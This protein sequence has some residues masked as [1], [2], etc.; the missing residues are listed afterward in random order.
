MQQRHVAEFNSFGSA[1][2]NP[3][4][5]GWHIFLQQSTLIPLACWTLTNMICTNVEVNFLFIFQKHNFVKENNSMFCNIQEH[6][7]LF[8][9]E[10]SNFINFSDICWS[11]PC[12]RVLLP[13]PFGLE[14]DNFRRKGWF[15]EIVKQLKYL[16]TE[17]PKLTQ[18]IVWGASFHQFQKTHNL[19]TGPIHVGCYHQWSCDYNGNRTSSGFGLK[20]FILNWFYFWTSLFFFSIIWVP[21]CQFLRLVIHSDSTQW[22]IF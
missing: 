2:N 12:T 15:W 11:C 6:S 22:M 20:L 16:Q 19:L 21:S 3:F 17:S 8:Y 18:A 1:V 14:N 9:I 5:V 13:L 4:T 10:S 7:C